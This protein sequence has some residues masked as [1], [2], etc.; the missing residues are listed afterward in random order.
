MSALFAGD[1]AAGVMLG[2]SPWILPVI[3]VA[4]K[5]TYDHARSAFR[6]VLRRELMS[7]S[8]DKITGQLNRSSGIYLLTGSNSPRPFLAG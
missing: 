8:P 6:I 1:A 5:L 3:A 2:L 4:A 7:V